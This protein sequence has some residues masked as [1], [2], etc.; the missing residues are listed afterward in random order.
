MRKR[1]AYFVV[2]ERKQEKSE[3]LRE[4]KLKK[5]FSLNDL[6]QLRLDIYT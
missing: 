3:T 2:R 6:L 5:Y 4:T 1:P